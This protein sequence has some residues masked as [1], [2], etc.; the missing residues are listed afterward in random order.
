MNRAVFID[1]DGTLVHDL[2]YNVDPARVQLREEAKPALAAL[3]AR[4]YELILV[5]N[6]SG[7]A[8]GRFAEVELNKVWR[9]LD[10]LLAD[11]AL[12]AIYYCPHFAQGLVA[13]Y[14]R[15]CECR[16]PQPGLLRR[17]ADER[18][19]DLQASW[20]IGDILDDIEAG[21]RAGCRTV[22]L[23]VDSE[24]QWVRGPLRTPDFVATDLLQAAAYILQQ[25]PATL[26]A[27]A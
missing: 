6:Q 10:E 25:T 9:C 1:K 27:F 20:M 23:D 7:V 26:R 8:L 5:S 15:D 14:N 21:K 24:T 12:D 3:R 18:D 16:K 11:Q 4:G 2:P 19:I 22:L 17:A 13:P